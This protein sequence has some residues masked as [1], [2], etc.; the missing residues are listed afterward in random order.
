MTGGAEQTV[1][2]PL[3]L[4]C[5]Y[6]KLTSNAKRH[7]EIRTSLRRSYDDRTVLAL[8]RN[9]REQVQQLQRIKT[10]QKRIRRGRKRRD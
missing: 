7:R 5:Q 4:L 8:M 6:A 3:D 2:V 9:E 10:I 1:N